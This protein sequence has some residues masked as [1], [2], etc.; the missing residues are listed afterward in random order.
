MR[1][2]RFSASEIKFVLTLVEEHLRPVQLARVGEAPTKRAMYRFYRDLGEAL[3]GVLFIALAD[4]AASRG[5][6]LTSDGWSRH[7]TYMNALFVRSIEVEGIVSRPALL[8]GHDLMEAL[9]VPPGPAIGELLEAVREAEAMGEVADRG[10]A[11]VLVRRLSR[12]FD[13]EVVPD[14]TTT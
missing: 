14:I 2:L 7:V 4:A 13:E 5:P 6:D 12:K 9:D 3:P 10:A 1:R 8:T 11:L